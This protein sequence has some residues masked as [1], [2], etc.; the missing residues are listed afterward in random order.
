MVVKTLIQIAATL[1]VIAL[2]SGRLP[3]ILKEVRLAQLH[4]LKES[5]A[6]MWGQPL[7]P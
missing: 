3:S 1:T 7:L 5:Q 4:L 6:S 2:S